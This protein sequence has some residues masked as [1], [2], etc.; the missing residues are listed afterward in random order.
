VS[1][2]RSSHITSMHIST[3]QSARPPTGTQEWAAS[4]VNIQDGCEHD[5]RYCYAK[6]M[7][8]RFKRATAASWRHPKLRQH[9]LDRGFTKRSGRIMFPTAHDI[10]PRNL[11]AC[12]VVLRRMLAAGNEVLIVSKPRVACISRLCA[13]LARYREQIVIR[14]SIGSTDDTVLSYW[15]PGAPPFAE[16][17]A[18]LKTAHLRDFNTSVSGEPMLDGNPDA[19]I[20]AVRPYVTDS[21]WLGKI[22]RLRNILPLNCPRDPEAIR[23]GEALM[24]LQSDNAI[25]ALHNRYRHDPKVKWK[26]SIKTVVGLK[27]PDSVGL[28]E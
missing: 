4:N 13:E 25:R 18:S 16:R 19:L 5:C 14:F 10:T 7:A 24:A 27:R 8:I 1:L 20:A 17:L 12:L 26:D 22:N 6:T 2:N 11:D 28:D 15:E 9:D 23:R 3:I 21:I